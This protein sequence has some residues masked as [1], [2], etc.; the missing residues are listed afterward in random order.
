[1]FMSWQRIQKG[2]K[3]KFSK[4]RDI[5]INSNSF[6]NKIMR[7]SCQKTYVQFERKLNKSTKH[8]EHICCCFK[9]RRTW[10][11]EFYTYL[12]KN[13]IS[14]C[15]HPKQLG[16][17]FLSWASFWYNFPLKIRRF[18]AKVHFWIFNSKE[19][20]TLR[21]QSSCSV[22]FPWEFSH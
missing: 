5:N 8:V 19:N 18:D 7:L 13:K 6:C 16:L 2:L 10:T 1:M 4:H 15:I 22:T 17:L 14:L 9:C 3:C 21:H 20:F 11:F 12:S